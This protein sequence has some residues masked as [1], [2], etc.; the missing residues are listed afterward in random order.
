MDCLSLYS[1]YTPLLDIFVFSIS[2][3]FP[4]IVNE[5]IRILI[6]FVRILYIK[7]FYPL[8]CDTIAQN[9]SFILTENMHYK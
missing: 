5:N 8:F 4:I 2:D 7:F 3:N 6:K 9:K 1:F